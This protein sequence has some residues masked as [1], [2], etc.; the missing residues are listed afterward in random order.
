MGTFS[1]LK[2]LDPKFLHKVCCEMELALALESFY[3]LPSTWSILHLGLG[4]C[5]GDESI[6]CGFNGNVTYLCFYWIKTYHGN[7]TKTHNL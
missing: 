3:N 2:K 4:L 7:H 5:L 1:I 6:V